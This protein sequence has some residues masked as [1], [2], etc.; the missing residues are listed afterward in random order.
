MLED[1]L[2]SDD[3]E[4]LE[5]L[6]KSNMKHKSLQELKNDENFFKSVDAYVDKI[7]GELLLMA[8]Q[9]SLKNNHSF[10]SL[11]ELCQFF[12]FICEK[13][14]LPETCYMMDKLCNSDDNTIL[15]SVCTMFS[16]YIGTF[17]FLAVQKIV[18]C[19]SCKMNVD[20]SNPSNSCY[21]AILDPSNSIRDYLQLNEEFYDY[22]IKEREHNKSII[23]DI[24]DGKMYRN[25]KT[26]LF[27]SDKYNYVSAALNS[28]GA[29]LFKSSRF[30][31]WPIYSII[32]ETPIQ[33]RL[34]SVIVTGLWYGKNK[35]DMSIFLDKFTEM[36]NNLSESEV[37]C[38]IKGEPRCLKVYA[39]LACVDS[40]ARALMQGSCQFNAYNGCNWCKHPDEYFARS[41]RYPYEVHLSCNRDAATIIEFA[42]GL[43]KL[44]K[45]F[46]E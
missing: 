46:L 35:T 22:V 8:L 7:S 25:F 39:I 19:D 12:N 3:E 18:Q 6:K 15:H 14:I 5:N 2:F 23:K 4:T 10:T 24:Y 1:T 16:K 37:Q 20:I 44:E 40:S 9:F 28:D 13:S 42:K 11:T 17:T 30:S 29:P 21:F 27:D 43:Y 38:I 26:N 45:P 36:M 33:N 31:I 34:N 32:N 41:M